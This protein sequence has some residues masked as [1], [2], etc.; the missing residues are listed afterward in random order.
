MYCEKILYHYKLLQ[1]SKHRRSQGVRWVP[2][3]PQGGGANLQGK[4]VSAPPGRAR[5]QFLVTWGIWTVG[6]VIQVVLASGLTAMTKK[7]RQLF[8]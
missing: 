3:H 4:V 1:H 7:C 8:W 5:V 6:E 2:V